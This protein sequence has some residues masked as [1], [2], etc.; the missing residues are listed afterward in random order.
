VIFEQRFRVVVVDSSDRRAAGRA[1]NEPHGIRCAARLNAR[2]F[3]GSVSAVGTAR[4]C[5]GNGLYE[6]C[7]EDAR[8]RSMSS[9]R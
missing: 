9:I 7:R 1:L 6:D 3:E 2:E 4:D 5:H 8:S